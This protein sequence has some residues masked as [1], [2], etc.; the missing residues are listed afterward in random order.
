MLAFRRFRRLWEGTQGRVVGMGMGRGWGWEGGG[1]GGVGEVVG[2]WGFGGEGTEGE[3]GVK[4]ER[5]WDYLAVARQS[6]KRE[7]EG[8]GTRAGSW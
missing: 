2:G 8:M 7:D 4:E 6:L 5:R 3:G 1:G